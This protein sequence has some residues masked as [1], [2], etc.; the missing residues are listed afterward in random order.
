MACHLKSQNKNEGKNIQHTWASKEDKDWLYK[1][2]H[3]NS[4]STI[5]G[6]MRSG[7]QGPSI[8]NRY[9]FWQLCAR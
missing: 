3:H 2:V 8:I 6:N 9:S 1:N 4:L 5:S 7:I